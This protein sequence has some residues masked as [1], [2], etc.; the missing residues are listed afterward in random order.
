MAEEPSQF[1]DF[2]G[3]YE[4]PSDDPLFDFDGR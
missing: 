4:D 3:R 2:D 1:S